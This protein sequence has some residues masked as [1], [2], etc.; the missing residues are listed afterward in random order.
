MAKHSRVGLYASLLLVT[1]GRCLGAEYTWTGATDGN[2]AT[3]TNWAGGVPASAT[4]TAL[5]FGSTTQPN[6]TNNISGGLTL[7]ALEFL[8]TAGSRTISGNALIFDGIAPTIVNS[9]TAGNVTISA[10]ITLLQT[11]TVSGGP[12][13]SAQSIFQGAFSGTGGLNFG[14]ITTISGAS[15]YTGATLVQGSLGVQGS[16]ALG[17][18][19][20][21]TVAPGGELQLIRFNAET[22]TVINRTLTLGGLLSSQAQMAEFFDA[23]IP[24]ARY[25]GAITLSNNA[26]IHTFGATGF[27]FEA[28]EFVVSGPVNRAGHSLTLSTAGSYNTTTVSGAISGNGNLL[29]NP[30]GGSVAVGAVSGDGN[31]TFSGSGGTVS[32]GSLA[33]NGDLLIQPNTPF[34]Y[35]SISGAV[36]GNRNIIVTSGLLTL[37]STASTFTGSISLSGQSTLSIADEGRLGDASNTV[38]MGDGASIDLTSVGDFSRAISLAAGG[39]SITTGGISRTISSNISGTGSFGIANF[40][41]QAIVALSGSNSFAGGLSIGSGV[42]LTYSQDGNLGAAGGRVILSGGNLVLPGTIPT[43]TRDIEI[44][45]ASGSISGVAGGTYALAGSISGT[46]RLDLSGAATYQ[47]TGTNTAAGGISIT[48]NVGAPAILE[49]GSDSQLGGP[50]GVLN[51]GRQ[52]GFNVLPGT[53]RAIGDLTVAATR[54]TTF[55]S[56]TVDTNGHTVTFNQSI[57]GRGM[58]KTGEGTWILNSANTDSSDVNNVVIEQGT[59]R[60]GV[61]DAL[62][63]RATLQYLSDNAALD[64]AGFNLELASIDS[65]SATSTIQLGSGTLTLRGGSSVSSSI[66]GSGGVVLGK[67]GFTGGTTF[68]SGSNSFS[69]GITVREGSSLY[70]QNSDALGAPGNAITLDNGTL[71]VTSALTG[72]LVINNS[73]NLTI[74]SGG[75]TF[76]ADGQSIVIDSALGGTNPIRFLGGSGPGTDPKYDVR[77][78][79]T[80]NTFVGNVRLGDAQRSPSPV[81]IGIAGN[82]SLG[83]AGNTVTLGNS[84]F[85]G[86]STRVAQGGLRAYADIV[87]PGSRTIQLDGSNSQPESSGGIID[88]NGHTVTIEGAISE[89]T[90]GM[91]LLKVGL[92][93]LLL[94]GNNTYTGR[95]LVEEGAL[96]GSGSVQSIQVG[97]SGTLAPGSSAGLLTVNDELAFSGGTLAIELGGTVRG[98][99][100]DALDVGGAVSL[101][102]ATLEISFLDGFEGTILSTDVFTLIDAGAIFDSFGNVFSGDRLTTTDGFG[103]F[104]VTY[105]GETLVLSDYAAVPEPGSLAL[106]AAGALLIASRRRR[107]LRARAR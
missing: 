60:M 9:A 36:T 88:T 47:I 21:V 82:G 97:F 54:S 103:S 84:H 76:Q 80:G 6:T 12:S 91:Q 42:I 13:Y 24:G 4:D 50:N 43:F 105:S 66:T 78:M 107:A 72:P 56:M 32:I 34:A 40:S 83:D 86:E 63:S 38:T 64:L 44:D 61:N 55:R 30:N 71:A 23:P 8:S 37:S 102:G 85:D 3:G 69:G 49:I 51:I 79:N 11:L 27:D 59:L 100:Y 98:L 35:A 29:L 45:S 15:S 95:T 41:T 104:L 46:G 20:S 62:G 10:P 28:A 90:S 52:N 5:V 87:L 67:S 58:T 39:G 89:L 92:G 25:S 1:G 17:L 68:F 94:E 96:G 70:I 48:G 65:T 14:G 31:V 2:W 33:G 93:T 73:T 18:S 101:G 7:N 26:R 81:I 75:A 22:P 19:S 57:A 106:A 77:L 74:G 16:S 53:L 99:E